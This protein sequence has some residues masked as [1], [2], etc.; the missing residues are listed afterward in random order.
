M[1]TRAPPTVSGLPQI[2]GREEDEWKVLE[3][4]RVT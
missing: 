3:E 2:K 1:N 4:A